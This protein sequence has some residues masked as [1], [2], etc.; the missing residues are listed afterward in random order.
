MQNSTIV[1]W[2]DGSDIHVVEGLQNVV[3][4]AVGWYYGCAIVPGGVAAEETSVW[5]WNMVL[6]K[7]SMFITNSVTFQPQK[8]VGLPAGSVV[9]VVTGASHACVLI[10][11]SAATGGEVYCW[12][13]NGRGQLGQG[14][15][16]GTAGDEQGSQ[17]PLRVKGL[18]N[19][20]AL[21]VGPRATCA[22]T[23]SQRVVCWGGNDYGML[24][25]SVRDNEISLPTAMQGLCA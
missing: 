5:C 7:S 8:V 10:K 11:A 19:I 22:V 12:G 2:Y 18:S 17:M 24:A 6:Y 4:V 14:Y 16:S 3:R 23:A 9:D 15:V 21:F 13:F 20:I 25:T 1:C